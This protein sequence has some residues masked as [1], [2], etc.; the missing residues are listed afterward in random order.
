MYKLLAFL[1]RQ[2]PQIYAGKIWDA[3]CE[4]C[5]SWRRR[6]WWLRLLK[7]M[8]ASVLKAL[9]LKVQPLHPQS[10]QTKLEFYML[11][12]RCMAKQNDTESSS[13]LAL[14]LVLGFFCLQQDQCLKKI[15][16]LSLCP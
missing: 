5:S 10:T 4:A 9:P 6:L 12:R 8:K 11:M 13:C 7:G 16:K 15:S 2:A 1:L 14:L 3:C